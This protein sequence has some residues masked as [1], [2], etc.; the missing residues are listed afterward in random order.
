M[1]KSVSLLFK[2]ISLTAIA[3]VASIAFIV[4][5]DRVWNT[6]TSGAFVLFC[7]SVGMAFY[8][9]FLLPASDD[10]NDAGQI[11]SIG[12]IIFVLPALIVMSAIAFLLGLTGF[13]TIVWVILVLTIGTFVILV[14]LIKAAAS[15]INQISAATANASCKTEWLALLQSVN[16]IEVSTEVKAKLNSL[17]EKIQY[18]ASDSVKLNSTVNSEISLIVDKI[19]KLI[20][21]DAGIDSELSVMIED[22]IYLIEKRE[23]L[24]KK[25]RTKS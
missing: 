19:Y 20:L 21:T 9:P 25:A 22:T 6:T 24:L 5:P 7:I 2:I 15:Y 10:G 17:I 1:S 12:M 8:S 3:M 23:A 4:L 13:E 16:K 11:A 14:S 18:A